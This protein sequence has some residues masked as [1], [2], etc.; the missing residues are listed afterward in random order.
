M[1]K[2][3]VYVEVVLRTCDPIIMMHS[4]KSMMVDDMLTWLLTI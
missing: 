4:E 2:S 1:V 3:V